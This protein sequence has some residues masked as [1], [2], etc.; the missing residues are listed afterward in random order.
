MIDVSSTVCNQS[1]QSKADS[2]LYNLQMNSPPVRPHIFTHTH[3]EGVLQRTE[4][5]RAIVN[6][7]LL[8]S[9]ASAL[10]LAVRA[11]AAAQVLTFTLDA[12]GC[13]RYST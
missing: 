11:D 3:E 13:S 4:L 7:P 9:K 6:G 5:Q 10:A 8:R 12:C 2:Q 1:P